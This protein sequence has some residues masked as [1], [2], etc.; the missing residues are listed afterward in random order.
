V[1]RYGQTELSNADYVVAIGGDGTPLKAHHATLAMSPR[2]VFA[3]RTQGSIGFL[4]NALHTDNLIS[5]LRSGRTIA[6]HPLRADIEQ[7]DGGGRTLFGINEIVF[8]RQRLQTA[9][10]QVMVE[11]HHDAIAATGDGLLLATPLGS[12]AYNRAVGG[13]RLPVG[14]GLLVLRGIAIRQPAHWSPIV[15]DDG[16]AVELEVLEAVHH[17]VRADTSTDG[18]LNVR[19][20]RLCCDRN[21]TLRLVFDQERGEGPEG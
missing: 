18:V 7:T 12:T 3:M 17:P 19:R 14:S 5:R 6:F 20:A 9:K 16:A 8:F 13:P 4:G 1:K 10:L 15:L 2:P 11:R 21:H